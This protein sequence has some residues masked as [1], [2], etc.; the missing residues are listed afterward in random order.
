MMGQ[1]VDCD[2][3]AQSDA[4]GRGPKR[5]HA[6]PSSSSVITARAAP[7]SEISAPGE[8]VSLSH[9][10]QQPRHI[11]LAL[12]F[13][14]RLM[15][16]LRSS[17]RCLPLRGFSLSRDR[18]LEPP[19]QTRTATPSAKASKSTPLCTPHIAIRFPLGSTRSTP[20]SYFPEPNSSAAFLAPPHSCTRNT[21]ACT[22]G[23]HTR[24]VTRS[25]RCL[26]TRQ[27]GL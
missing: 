5:T 19:Q 16:T 23:A 12:Y 18:Q 13:S 7:N 8:G 10:R 26:L 20:H 14:S 25:M 9:H 17:S 27:V 11:W 3:N 21:F 24:L 1:C 15:E 22:I 6:T 4:A 2:R